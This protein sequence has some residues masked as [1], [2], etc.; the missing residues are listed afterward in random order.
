MNDALKFV[1]ETVTHLFWALLLQG[2]AFVLL[3]ILILIYPEF[4]FALVSATF[5]VIGVGLL[6]LAWKVYTYWRKVPKFLK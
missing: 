4:L 2:T 1:K 6:L 5:L 3:A